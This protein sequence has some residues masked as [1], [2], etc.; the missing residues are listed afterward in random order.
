MKKTIILLILPLFA[1]TFIA[2]KKNNEEEQG[3]KGKLVKT[4]EYFNIQDTTF[5]FLFTTH[6]DNQ[7]RLIKVEWVQK[8]YSAVYNLYTINLQ[9]STNTIIS[10]WIHGGL[11]DKTY[12]LHLDNIGYVKYEGSG[13]DT[14]HIYTYENNYL[15]ERI[16]HGF[17][18]EYSWTNGNIVQMIADWPDGNYVETNYEYS[19]KEDL[20][21]INI[22]DIDDIFANNQ[23]Y[24]KVLK[25]KG[26]A[27][28]NY[29]V[30]AIKTNYPYTSII[31]YDYK[32]DKNGYPIQI[33]LSVNGGEELYKYVLT[34]Y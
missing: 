1:I 21:N 13:I 23:G 9:Y 24:A 22:L 3:K 12:T 4:V 27:S 33:L 26:L 32:F 34:Y 29:L 8:T 30:K 28:K 25:L 17:P 10:T 18:F 5:S 31:T 2:C 6:Y 11:V 20:L 19:S 7:D 14:C 15:K 16:S